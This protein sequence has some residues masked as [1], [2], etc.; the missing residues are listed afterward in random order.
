ME[1][2]AQQII[3]D[4]PHSKIPTVRGLWT[5][6]RNYFADL[7]TNVI[8]NAQYKLAQLKNQLVISG[9]EQDYYTDLPHESLPDALQL[10]LPQQIRTTLRF[11]YIPSFEV[12][13]RNAHDIDRLMDVSYSLKQF[14]LHPD[15]CLLPTVQDICDIFANYDLLSKALETNS[16]TGLTCLRATA[17]VRIVEEI[18]ADP[19]FSRFVQRVRAV[20]K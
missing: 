7:Q 12:R 20:A 18:I 11:S 6:A 16:V 17:Y 4:R 1:S 19:L 14:T 2:I 3:I 8:T 15:T 13:A 9:G 5:K 10:T